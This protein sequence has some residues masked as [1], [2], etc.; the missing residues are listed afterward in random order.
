MPTPIRASPDG[1][2][3]AVDA[4]GLSHATLPQIRKTVARSI[5]TIPDVSG[6][7][8]VLR[9]AGPPLAS[10]CIDQRF[11]SESKS[12]KAVPLRAI[13]RFSGYNFHYGPVSISPLVAV[14]A[15]SDT[16]ALASTTEPASL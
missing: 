13:L 7:N 3:L 16:V 4:I 2:L 8:T 9:I 12:A 10:A 15:L 1:G 14:V 6:L 5:A 11:T